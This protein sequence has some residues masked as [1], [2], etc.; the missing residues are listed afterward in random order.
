MGGNKSCEGEIR[1][2][3]LKSF[4]DITNKVLTKEKN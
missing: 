2:P 1:M 3:G 4:P